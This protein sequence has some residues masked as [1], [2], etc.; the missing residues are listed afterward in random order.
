MGMGADIAGQNAIA[1]HE[2]A[3]AGQDMVRAEAWKCRREG[4]E[5]LRSPPCQR[6]Q[7]PGVCKARKGSQVAR[8]AA[9]NRTPTHT[10]ASR[11]SGSMSAGTVSIDISGAF[12]IQSS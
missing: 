12:G 2:L 4:G 1:W 11:S 6:L 5:H 3:H 10:P 8:I 7:I 9:R